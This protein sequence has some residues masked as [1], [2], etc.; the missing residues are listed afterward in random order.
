LLGHRDGALLLRQ[1]DG[2]PPG[3]LQ[4]LH[5]ALPG[6]AVFLDRALRG[7]TG[8]IHRLAGGDLRAF[9]LLLPIGA[10]PGHVGSLGGALHLELALLGQP[11]VLELAV[12]IQGLALGLQ[13]LVPDLDHGVLLDVVANLLPPLDL[14]GEPGE[15]LR[16]EGVRGV[17][18]LHARLVE[19]GERHRL[20]LQPVLQEVARHHRLD[21]LDV[22]PP[23]LVHLLHGHLGGD[24]PKGVDELALDQLL[25]RLRLQRPLAQG[26]SGGGDGLHPCLDAHVELGDHVHAHAVLGDE[27]LVPAA[28]D[29]ETQGVHVDGHDLVDDRQYEGAAVHDHLLAAQPGAHEGALLGRAEVQPVHEPDHDRHHDGDRDEPEDRRAELCSCH[30]KPP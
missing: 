21:P 14:I 23:L 22:L 24:G 29:L 26:P 6:D 2:L 20:Q 28:R 10:L 7:D 8:A 4:L 27:R 3:D 30:D 25:E 9:G 17:E 19:L 13:V 16:V 5:L 1:L 11:R 12:D 18:E 15:A